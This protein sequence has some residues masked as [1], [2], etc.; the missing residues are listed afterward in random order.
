MFG[1]GTGNGTE[2]KFGSLARGL[3]EATNYQFGGLESGLE[4]KNLHLVAW[5]G[6]CDAKTPNLV[7]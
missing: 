1:R 4:T 2:T 3:G 5:K 6:A 7:A